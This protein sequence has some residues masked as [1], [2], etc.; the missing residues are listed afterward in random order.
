MP[1]CNPATQYPQAEVKSAT[2]KGPGSGLA[3]YPGAVGRFSNYQ[4]QQQQYREQYHRQEHEYPFDSHHQQGF[5]G[6]QVGG[7]RGW[8]SQRGAGRGRGGRGGG[9]GYSVE[10]G[11]G[12]GVRGGG[13]VYRPSWGDS[14][15]R[16]QVGIAGG[17]GGGGA[18][19]AGGQ[20]ARE[21][22]QQLNPGYGHMAGGYGELKS[23]NVSLNRLGLLIELKQ[24]SDLWISFFVSGYGP[25]G[26][27]FVAPY[28]NMLGGYA[29]GSFPPGNYPPGVMMQGYG[30]MPYGQMGYGGPH[31]PQTGPYAPVY[32]QGPQG[33]QQQQQPKQ[34]QRQLSAS[35]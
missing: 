21:Q 7:G 11:G 15:E 6:Q 12:G 8:P 17:L 3:A 29:Q 1:H 33:M 24:S 20:G 14:P 18:T 9:G 13:G 28:G 25:M 31:Y 22:Q 35:R 19:S 23:S 26:V 30:G 10:A 2:P 27:P 34:L 4:N 16:S 32:P 5:G